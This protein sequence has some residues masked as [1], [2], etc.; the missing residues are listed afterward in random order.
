MK[1]YWSMGEAYNLSSDVCRS[2]P[3]ILNDRIIVPD[4]ETH[5]TRRAVMV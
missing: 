1:Y 4:S 3:L 2:L 5:G